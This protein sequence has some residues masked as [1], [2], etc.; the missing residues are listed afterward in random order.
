M[1]IY[2]NTKV[3]TIFIENQIQYKTHRQKKDELKGY[4]SNPSSENNSQLSI[5]W[6][7][8]V[9]SHRSQIHKK[10]H[11]KFIFFAPRDNRNSVNI[12]HGLE[13]I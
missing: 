1:H 8:Y 12:R 13:S 5:K 4:L 7:H 2:R 11:E 10:N 9:K 3:K 6:K